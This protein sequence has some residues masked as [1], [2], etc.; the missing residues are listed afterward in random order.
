MDL[1]DFSLKH[2]EIIAY[3]NRLEEKY[4]KNGV[5]GFYGYNLLVVRV[6]EKTTFHSRIAFSG[7]LCPIFTH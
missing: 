2:P 7:H 5:E 1:I 3:I 4:H 6:R